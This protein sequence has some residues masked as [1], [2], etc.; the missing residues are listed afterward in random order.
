[1]KNDLR[2]WLRLVEGRDAPLYHMMDL[3]KSIAVFGND[4]LPSRWEHRILG[5]DTKYGTSLSRNSRFRFHDDY[6]IR[7]TF[8]QAKLAQRYKLIPLDAESA[9]HFS[10]EPRNYP[11]GKHRDRVMNQA[12]NKFSFSEEFLLG[13][14]NPLNRYLTAIDLFLTRFPEGA[15]EKAFIKLVTTY[16]KQHNIP[17]RL[18][19]DERPD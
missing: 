9:Y 13:D 6:L 19:D 5:N 4:I 7:L 14:V 3:S 2:W 1:M 8:D 12:E 18:D 17:L 10:R 16:A 11:W 15:D